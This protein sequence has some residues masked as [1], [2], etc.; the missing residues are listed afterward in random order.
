MVHLFQQ[1]APRI[2]SFILNALIFHFCLWYTNTM[3]KTVK[4]NIQQELRLHLFTIEQKDDALN[5][6][7]CVNKLGPKSI[8]H[9]WLQNIPADWSL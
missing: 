1:S 5:C 6:R 9:T 3:V 4:L 2:I 7:S 8:T